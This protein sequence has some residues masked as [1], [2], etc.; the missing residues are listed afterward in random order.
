MLGQE[1]KS[2]TYI[3]NIEFFFNDNCCIGN[4][5]PYPTP[6]GKSYNFILPNGLIVVEVVIDVV[7]AVIFVVDGAIVVASPLAVRIF[8]EFQKFCFF[9]H[10]NTYL[11]DNLFHRPFQASNGEHHHTLLQLEG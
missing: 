10:P 5:F 6:D 8:F 3:S 1:F 9:Y 7:D 4:N 11:L 2:P